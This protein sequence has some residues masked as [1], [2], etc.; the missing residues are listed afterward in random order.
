M[1]DAIWQFKQLIQIWIDCIWQPRQLMLYKNNI[2]IGSSISCHYA[3]RN[4]RGAA[5]LT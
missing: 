3:I 1:A 2:V 4:K 5:L